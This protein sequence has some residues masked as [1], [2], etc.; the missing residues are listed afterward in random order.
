M[1]PVVSIA[2]PLDDEPLMAYLLGAI[3]DVGEAFWRIRLVWR[4][5]SIGT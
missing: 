3:I 1:S 2:L 4:D 5:L